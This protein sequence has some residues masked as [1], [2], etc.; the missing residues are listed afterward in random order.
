MQWDRAPQGA[1]EL[2]N[3]SGRRSRAMVGLAIADVRLRMRY[4]RPLFL[5]AALLVAPAV[6]AKRH[7]RHHKPRRAA[8]VTQ[9]VAKKT[10][11]RPTLTAFDRA[12]LEKP[13]AVPVAAVAQENDDETPGA[14]GKK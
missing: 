2:I 14:R 9:V 1:N 4:L 13:V 8:K 3:E 5:I 12:V 10:Q 7:K 11:P 6:E